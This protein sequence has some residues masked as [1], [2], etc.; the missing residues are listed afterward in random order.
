M[1]NLIAKPVALGLKKG[2]WAIASAL[3]FGL[4]ATPALAAQ[5]APKEQIVQA[6]ASNFHEKPVG[7]GATAAGALVIMF[8]SPA[9]TW[10]AVSVQ[11]S[12]SACVLDV[13]DGW[14]DLSQPGVTAQ[15]E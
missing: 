11:P 13:G 12:G 4:L 7:M 2:R 14:T 6:L 10:T 3:A 8:A 15:A 9:G 5:C 1:V